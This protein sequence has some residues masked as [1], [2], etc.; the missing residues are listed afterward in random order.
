MLP[1]VVVVGARPVGARPVGAGLVGLPEELHSKLLGLLMARTLGRPA[2]VC[3]HWRRAAGAPEPWRALFACRWPHAYA[4]A[5][6]GNPRGP[7]ARH[8]PAPPVATAALNSFQGRS[9][10]WWAGWT[11]R[12]TS[13]TTSGS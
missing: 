9:R 1:A 7:P 3:R 12:C 8:L 5:V 13:R 4:R 6:P 10:G 11:G 2:Q